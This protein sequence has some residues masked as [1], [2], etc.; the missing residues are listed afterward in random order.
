MNF[1][2]HHKRKYVLPAGTVWTFALK[3]SPLHNKHTIH[4]LW[5]DGGDDSRA[6]EPVL[7]ASEQWSNSIIP[8]LESTQMNPQPPHSS[9]D[10][11]SLKEFMDLLWAHDWKNDHMP[12]IDLWHHEWKF[13]GAYMPNP[14]YD[15]DGHTHNPTGEFTADAPAFF[16]YGISLYYRMINEIHPLDITNRSSVEFYFDE[17]FKEIRSKYTLSED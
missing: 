7:K 8:I 5:Y 14:W 11:K 13:H 2:K 15:Y 4:G 17:N 10:A 16:S 1:R 12:N 3:W 6:D 9:K